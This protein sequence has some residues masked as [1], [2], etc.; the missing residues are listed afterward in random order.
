MKTIFLILLI[1]LI[2]LIITKI[3]Y[4]NFGTCIYTPKTNM[5]LGLDSEIMFKKKC[6]CNKYNLDY[7]HCYKLLLKH[8]KNVFLENVYSKINKNFT[9]KIISK[10]KEIN[11]NSKDCYKQIN[12]L[13]PYSTSL[14]TEFNKNLEDDD[15]SINIEDDVKKFIERYEF[16]KKKITK[17]FNSKLTIIKIPKN[18]KPD[19]ENT[20]NTEDTEETEEEE[21][22]VNPSKFNLEKY[23]I[24]TINSEFLLEIKYIIDSIDSDEKTDNIT[25]Y[26]VKN[27][28]KIF[29]ENHIN[30]N[31]SDKISQNITEKL[32]SS[33]QVIQLY[34]CKLSNIKY[35]NNN[36]CY[37]ENC[38]RKKKSDYYYKLCNEKKKKFKYNN[39]NC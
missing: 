36:C 3:R 10:I 8:Y 12:D 7:F 33:S 4:E 5:I 18:I 34:Y 31:N 11:I 16:I 14:I 27:L 13:S 26:D 21:I 20:E 38:E 9:D 15:N 22:C 35:K 32:S 6:L 23:I 39:Y 2:F 24:D 30:K 37:Q 1:F 25:M 19:I 29:L 17:E 28:Q